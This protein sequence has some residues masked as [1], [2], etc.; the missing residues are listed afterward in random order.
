MITEA[1]G[2]V[3]RGVLKKKSR[4]SENGGKHEIKIPCEN[5]QYI[6]G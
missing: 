3:L 1:Y 5:G 2:E 6:H 4:C